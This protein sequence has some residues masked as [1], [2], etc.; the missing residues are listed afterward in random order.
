[1]SVLSKFH[2]E[3]LLPFPRLYQRH[4]LSPTHRTD[5]WEVAW[6]HFYLLSP[7]Q[8]NDL[9]DFSKMHTVFF[10]CLLSV[11][12]YKLMPHSKGQRP[13]FCVFTLLP[14]NLLTQ[15]LIE[16][17]QLK[18]AFIPSCLQLLFL[19]KDGEHCSRF[20]WAEPFPH[21]LSWAKH[22]SL[23]WCHSPPRV[24][25]LLVKCQQ[26]FK[27]RRGGLKDWLCHWARKQ[28]LAFSCSHNLLR[29][30]SSCLEELCDNM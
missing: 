15:R 23:N 29:G 18:T 6:C 26:Y 14:W 17:A 11:S 13:L 27:R 4:S 5:L 22:A 25:L 20:G 24:F 7:T 3:A 28:R 9:W 1:M 12:L 10:P 2:S 30:C 8:T 16:R 21:F 19:P